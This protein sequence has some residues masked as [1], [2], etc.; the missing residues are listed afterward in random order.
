MRPF[1]WTTSGE[2]VDDEAE[3]VRDVAARLDAGDALRA[4]ARYLNDTGVR[5]VMG[6]TWA[7]ITVRRMVTSPRMVGDVAGFPPILDRIL[8]GRLRETLLDPAQAERFTR[9]AVSSSSWLSGIARCGRCDATLY[10]QGEQLKCTATADGARCGSV[11]IGL[12]MVESDAEARI[13][14]RLASKP[15]RRAL[16]KLPTP[17][18]IDGQIE[19]A[20]ERGV[21]LAREFGAGVIAQSAFEAGAAAVRESVDGLVQDRK[22]AVLAADLPPVDGLPEWWEGLPEA[23]RRDVADAAIERLSVQ[24]KKPG[25]DRLSYA[26][27]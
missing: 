26:W 23:R 25:A 12:R 5:T 14:G 18:E 8:W 9:K 4:V 7:S 24:P 27:R 20:E 2:I 22:R 1:G 15:A 17:D 11:S 3:V 19:A 10:V 21:V 13:L 16:E 6:K